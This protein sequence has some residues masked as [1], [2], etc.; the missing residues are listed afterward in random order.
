MTEIRSGDVLLYHGRG[1][2]S[3]AIRKFDGTEVNHAAIALDGERLGEAAG[4]GLQIAPIPGRGIR[5]V[6]ARI[7][8]STI[9][10]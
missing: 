3:W 4:R 6:E 2:I 9:C 5:R 10:W 8:R 1:F 7:A